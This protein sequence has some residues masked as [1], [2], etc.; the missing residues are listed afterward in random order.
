[1]FFVKVQVNLSTGPSAQFS[2]KA[3]IQLISLRSSISGSSGSNTIA[4]ITKYYLPPEIVSQ[5]PPFPN[6][7]RAVLS[8]LISDTKLEEIISALQNYSRSYSPLIPVRL[9]SGGVS[10]FAQLPAPASYYV[11]I[12]DSRGVEISLIPIQSPIE[13]DLPLKASVYH[14]SRV[15]SSKTILLVESCGDKTADQ[16]G[17]NLLRNLA[18]SSGEVRIHWPQVGRINVR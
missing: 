10:T 12:E 1:M 5:I 6:D 14:I 7:N 2:H 13:T 18:I 17:V 9:T 11:R 16:F 4:L 3:P 8:A 15:A